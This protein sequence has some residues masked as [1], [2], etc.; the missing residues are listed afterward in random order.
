MADKQALL[1]FLHNMDHSPNLNWYKRSSV[2][3]RWTG[4]TC[5]TE[6][7]QVIAPLILDFVHC[8]ELEVTYT[9]EQGICYTSSLDVVNHKARALP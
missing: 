7:S 9:T 4:V 1:D 6:Q 5:N 3:K 2:C 8:S